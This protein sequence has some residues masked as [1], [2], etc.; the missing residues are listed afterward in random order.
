[1]SRGE[2]ADAVAAVLQSE[3]TSQRSTQAGEEGWSPATWT[4]LVE[5][6]F[7][8]LGI[9]E[10]GGGGGGSVGDALDVIETVGRFAAP[11]PIAEAG[12]VAPWL[13]AEAGMRQEP[14][15]LLTVPGTAPLPSVACS[16]HGN[17]YVLTGRF[18]RVPWARFADRL[19]FALE[20]EEQVA[21][22]VAALEDAVIEAGGNLAG[23]PRDTVVFEGADIPSSCVA[24]APLTV[25]LRGVQARGAL[26]RVALMAGALDQALELTVAYVKDRVQFGRPLA[27]FQLVQGHIAVLASQAAIAHMAVLAAGASWPAFGA[28]PGD[29][30]A[31]AAFAKISASRAAFEGARIAHQLHGAIGMTQEYAL[32]H[33]SR[34]LWSWAREFGSAD[35]WAEVIG[36]SVVTRG[37]D[38]FWEAL[39]GDGSVR[40]VD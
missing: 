39:T 29:E 16:R 14:G 27:H 31:A 8:G 20:V 6:G 10:S 12:F 4:T 23:E 28:A 7:T 32:Q 15:L 17:G 24:A 26:A 1:M 19:V 13:L 21:I 30:I 35:H 2:I 11:I 37:P 9:P 33:Y 18:D 25:T 5:L 34:R 38:Q 40:L 36:R 22:V 3:M